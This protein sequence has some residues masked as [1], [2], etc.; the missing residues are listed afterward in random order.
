M[1]RVRMTALLRA[2][3][4]IELLVVI[5]IIAILAAML[6]PALASAREKARRSTCMSQLNQ[7]GK[8]FES[9]TGDYGGYVPAGHRWWGPKESTA[10]NPA[11]WQTEVYTDA[12]TGDK[13]YGSFC[14]YGTMEYRWAAPRWRCIGSGVTMTNSAPNGLKVAPRGLGLLFSG[15]YIGDAGVFYCPSEGDIL[16][17]H[18]DGNGRDPLGRTFFENTRKQF[19]SKGPLSSSRTLTHGSWTNSNRKDYGELTNMGVLSHYAYRCT[20][21]ISFETSATARSKNAVYFT[22]PIIYADRGEGMFKSVKQLGGRAVVSDAWD[23][24]GYDTRVGVNSTILPGFGNYLHR[25]GYNVL[26]GDSHAAWFGDPE[27]KIVFWPCQDNFSAGSEG[28]INWRHGLFNCVIG[29][30]WTSGSGSLLLWH[31]L[32]VAG[33]VDASVNVAAWSTW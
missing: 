12:P 32:D 9:Y 29:D 31:N 26:Y 21:Q 14:N 25:D 4:L 10:A 2:F 6:L 22:S 33:G 11:P 30:R 15:N 24:P 7:M 13:V 8:A 28:D 5:A 18:A 1:L 19:V 17:E 3:T 23:K 27:L 20:T 16:F